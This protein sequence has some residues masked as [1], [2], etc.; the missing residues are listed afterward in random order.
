MLMLLR[1]TAKAC[2]P[3][4]VPAHLLRPRLHHRL[5]HGVRSAEGGE[6]GGGLFSRGCAQITLSRD[7]CVAALLSFGR[8]FQNDDFGSL[9]VGSDGGGDARCREPNNDHVCD[10]VPLTRH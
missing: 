2:E 6:V 9:T 1:I 3:V 8:L 5:R 10:H 4:I 7:P